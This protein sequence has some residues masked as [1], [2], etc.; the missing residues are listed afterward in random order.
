MVEVLGKPGDH[1]TEIST[2]IKQNEL[3]LKFP[4]QVEEYAKNINKDKISKDKKFK[5][6]GVQIDNNSNEWYL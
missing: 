3:P 4:N 5:P 1:E 6:Y 2:I